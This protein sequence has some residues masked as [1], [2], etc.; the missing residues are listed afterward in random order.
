MLETLT[1]ESFAPHVE[2]VFRL[3]PEGAA[4]LELTLVSATP[5]GQARRAERFRERAFSVIFLG[6]PQAPVLPQQIYRLE[7]GALGVLE[8]FLV[9]IGAE[10]GRM[11]YEAVF[12]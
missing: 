8:I 12:N 10:E 6:P 4:G 5:V 1:S 11:R 9:P 2:T 7:H 3:G